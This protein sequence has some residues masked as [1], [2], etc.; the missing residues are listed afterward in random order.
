M[1]V[2]HNESQEHHQDGD[3][4]EKK[5]SQGQ[6]AERAGN[7]ELNAEP[8]APSTTSMLLGYA[9]GSV[10]TSS[11]GSTTT[12]NIQNISPAIANKRARKNAQSR[13]RA[14]V[15][16]DRINEIYKKPTEE[17]TAEEME[18]ILKNERRRDRKNSRSRERSLNSK[19]EIR[20]I[21]SIPEEE[22]TQE[23]REFLEKYTK[24]KNRKNEGDRLRRN[25]MKQVKVGDETKLTG[26]GHLI[27]GDQ[28]QDGSETYIKPDVGVSLH[29]QQAYLAAAEGSY[30][31]PSSYLAAAHSSHLDVPFP[32]YQLNQP[33]PI[34]GFGP[35]GL[36][37]FSSALQAASRHS[38]GS[39]DMPP[40]PLPD[41]ALFQQYVHYAGAGNSAVNL[42]PFPRNWEEA[43]VQGS[44]PET[45]TSIY[46]TN[47]RTTDGSSQKI[48]SGNNN[49]EFKSEPSVQALQPI[50]SVTG[51]TTDGVTSQNE[52]MD[53][54]VGI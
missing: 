1:G 10:T 28:L 35:N 30:S 49:E 25:R 45:T 47:E 51:L 5:E 12:S 29:P 7:W 39:N 27:K 53:E 11:I 32:P 14:A 46:T 24:Q 9:S 18:L 17:R 43:A 8:M 52:G 36:A 38:Q 44:V 41:A 6:Q 40:L 16:R 42:S 48:L 22:K 37:Q 34:Q 2:A 31:M 23:Q 4:N 13:A 33:M 19:H 50:S 3:K 15:L 21:M 54:V 26:R 20:R